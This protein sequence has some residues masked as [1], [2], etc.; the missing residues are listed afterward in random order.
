MQA[1]S[2]HFGLW[3]PS[4]IYQTHGKDQI[5]CVMHRQY[6]MQKNN[7]FES[8]CTPGERVEV[9]DTDQNNIKSK[10]SSPSSLSLV[11]LWSILK[12]RGYSTVDDDL[13]SWRRFDASTLQQVQHLIG[14]VAQSKE[15]MILTP[16]L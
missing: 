5:G 7:M 8:H 1:N 4:H 11:I 13:I 2:M 3:M 9:D 10:N 6:F 15:Q 12:V 16:K 14:Y